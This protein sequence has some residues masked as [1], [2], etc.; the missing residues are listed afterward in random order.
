[1]AEIYGVHTSFDSIEVKLDKRLIS[2]FRYALMVK[3]LWKPGLGSLV[4]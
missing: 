1:M 4:T 2:V 3:F